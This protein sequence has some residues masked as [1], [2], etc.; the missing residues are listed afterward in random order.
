MIHAVRFDNG[1]AR[2]RNRFVAHRVLRG[3][4]PRRPCRLRRPDGPDAGRSRR[5]RRRDPA[6]GSSA[7]IGVLH[8]GDHLLALGEVEPAWELSP[9]LDTLGARGPRARPPA[10]PRRP[11]PRR[12]RSPA[13]SSRLAY[14]PTS[15]T[16]T[17]HHIDRAGRL[18][19]SFHGR[20]RRAEHDP[21]LRPDRAPP[22][23]PD[24]PGGLR[25]GRGRAGRA[26]PAMAARPRHPH[27]RHR[28]RRRRRPLDRDRRLL[29][30]PLRQRLRARRATSSSTTSATTRC[31]L[32]YGA[33]RRH[34]PPT[35]PPPDHRPACGAH[36]RRRRC[37]TRVVEFPRID[38]RRVARPSALRL[39][40]DPDRHAE[41]RAT[42]PRRPSTAC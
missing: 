10:R 3:R 17:I 37:S 22:R 27:R 42:R 1:R 13:T 34:A 21:R 36:R 12:I 5:P 26:L 23:P 24:R 11:Q 18:R 38:D 33:R 28:P 35:P 39:R 14:D 2:Y 31:N 32:G 15:P 9:D 25:H 40:P 8:H 16:V 19:R 20:P 29:R 6:S 7:F 4:G 41:D 30:L